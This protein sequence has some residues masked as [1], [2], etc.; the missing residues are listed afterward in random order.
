MAIKRLIREG[1][2]EATQMSPEGTWPWLVIKV[3][4]ECSLLGA[5]RAKQNIFFKGI[6]IQM[7]TSPIIYST[8]KMK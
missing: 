4:C 2:D 8:E 5:N 6:I 7:Q 1:T 3:S